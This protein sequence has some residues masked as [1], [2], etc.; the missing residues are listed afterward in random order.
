MGD[1]QADLVILGKAFG[2]KGSRLAAIGAHVADPLQ[3]GA[4]KAAAHPAAGKAA[5]RHRAPA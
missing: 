2:G 4:G 3:H 5:P 1:Q